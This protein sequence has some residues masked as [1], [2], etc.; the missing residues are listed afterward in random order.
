MTTLLK[1]E[2]FRKG[3]LLNDRISR[4]LPPLPRFTGVKR[5]PQKRHKK[6]TKTIHFKSGNYCP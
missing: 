6:T 2:Y 1:N 5:S 4:S 3:V